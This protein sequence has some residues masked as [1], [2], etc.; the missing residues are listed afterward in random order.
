M[1]RCDARGAA[2]GNLGIPSVGGLTQ[3]L[4]YG[5]VENILSGVMVDAESHYPYSSQRGASVRTLEK[6]R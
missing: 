3:N 2:G 1:S 6:R 4:N 5:Q